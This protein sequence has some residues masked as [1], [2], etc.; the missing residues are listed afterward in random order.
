MGFAPSAAFA[1]FAL[2]TGSP[3]SGYISAA[4]F[5]KELSLFFFSRE[6]SRMLTSRVNKA[7]RFG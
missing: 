4:L 3:A 7:H 2:R 5:P 1:L 6:G